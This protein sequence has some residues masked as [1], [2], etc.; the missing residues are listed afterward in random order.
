MRYPCKRFPSIFSGESEQY[1]AGAFTWGTDE[2]GGKCLWIR[3]PQVND[4]VHTL[5]SIPITEQSGTPRIGR[6]TAWFW[7]G[8]EDRPT[9]YPNLCEVGFAGWLTEGELRSMGESP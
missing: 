5:V 4:T 7:N 6:E 1:G 8:D 9:L 3:L 2:R